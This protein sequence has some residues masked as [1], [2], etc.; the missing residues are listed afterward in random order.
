MLA[1]LTAV[2]LARLTTEVHHSNISQLTHLATAI[3]IKP[4]CDLK[5]LA[6]DSW[7][8]QFS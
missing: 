8:Q 5:S 4:T 2:P 6:V 3:A 7:L 1:A